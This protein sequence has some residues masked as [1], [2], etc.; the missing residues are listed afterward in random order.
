MGLLAQTDIY[1]SR[2]RHEEYDTTNPLTVFEKAALTSMFR[3]RAL[4]LWYTHSI[5][6]FS[7]LD[8]AYI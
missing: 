5:D 8:M 3:H 7:S 2:R 1:H 4:Y 6:L